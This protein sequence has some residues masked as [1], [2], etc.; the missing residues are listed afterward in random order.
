MSRTISVSEAKNKFSAM[1]DWAIQNKEGVVVE[2]RGQPK[3]VILSYMEYEAYL[4]LREKEQRRTA[5]QRMEVLAARVREQNQDLSLDEAEQIA[6]E[7]SRETIEGMVA[8]EKV[9][10]KQT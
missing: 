2:S 6:D 5:L 10:F 7:I 3:A 1:L 4:S 9:S 8:K